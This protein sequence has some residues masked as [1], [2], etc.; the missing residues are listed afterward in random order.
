MIS[1]PE[2][3]PSF[4]ARRFVLLAGLSGVLYAALWFFYSHPDWRAQQVLRELFIWPVTLG[5]VW[6]YWQGYEA[7]RPEPPR[8]K[9]MLWLALA[10]ALLAMAVPPFHSTDLF[11]YINRGWQQVA[12][13]MNPYVHPVDDIPGWEHDP[14]ITDHWVNNPSPYGFVYLQVARLLAWLGGGSLPQT[15]MVFKAFNLLLHLG[16]G[17]MVWLVGRRLFS[18]AAALR[19]FYLYAFNPLILVHALCNGH[20]DILMGAL[21]TLSAWLAVLGAAWAVLPALVAATLVKYAALVILPLA[22][23]LLMK[24][25]RWAAL[26]VGG[27]AALGVFLLSGSSYLPDWRDF[28]VDR[29][30]RN[31]FVSHSSLHSVFFNAYEDLG[32]FVFPAMQPYEQAVRSLLKNSLLLAYVLFYATLCWRILKAP[33]YPVARFIRD[34]LL[35]MVVLVGIVSLK[36]YP[37]YLGMFLPLAFLLPEGDWLRRFVVVYSGFQMLALTFIGQTHYLNFLLMSGVPMLW[38][39]RLHR[40]AAA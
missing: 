39:W 12:Y 3:A 29:I 28:A 6:A 14:M 16:V 19:G 13:G 10:V 11:G 7:M 9:T 32:H 4:T 24:Q 21:V 33:E 31:A 30:Q 5:L 17:A 26:A 22:G 15:I 8:L 35:V 40:K 37:W 1:K 36:F 34:A 25:R 2:P 23:L 38:M 20:N 18:E 27:M